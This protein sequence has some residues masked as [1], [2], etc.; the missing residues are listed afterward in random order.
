M[1]LHSTYEKI[2]EQERSMLT[3]NEDEGKQGMENL[4][5]ETK[6]HSFQAIQ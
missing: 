6:M 5:K 3:R 2:K 1:E 4:Q